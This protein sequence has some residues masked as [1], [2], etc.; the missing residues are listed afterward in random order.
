MAVGALGDRCTSALGRSSSELWADASWAAGD[1]VIQ[2]PGDHVTYV[3]PKDAQEPGAVRGC[4]QT[5]G[6]P[7]ESFRR[8]V[9][10]GGGLRGG[11]FGRVD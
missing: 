8:P 6:S 9:L 1:T 2:H 10:L 3:H 4:N 11:S 5:P 7:G